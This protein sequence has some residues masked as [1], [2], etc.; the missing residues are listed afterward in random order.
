MTLLAGWPAATSLAVYLR[1]ARNRILGASVQAATKYALSVN[2][3]AAKAL[4]LTLPPAVL[5]RADA[6]IE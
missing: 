3:K 1:L 5:A 6:V 2:F 4:G